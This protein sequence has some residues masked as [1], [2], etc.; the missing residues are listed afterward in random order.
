MFDFDPSRDQ[1]N[2]REYT[3]GNNKLRLRRQDPYGF[4]TVSY[5]RGAAP[6]VLSGQYTSVSEAEKAIQSYLDSKG[7]EITAKSGK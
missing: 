7:R 3:V 6:D 5:E 2:Q 4:W 1:P